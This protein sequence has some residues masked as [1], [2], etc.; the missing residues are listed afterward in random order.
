MTRGRG[1]LSML[2]LLLAAVLTACTGLPT[3]GTVNY[4]LGA[5]DAPD[6]DEVS[7]LL[8]DRPQP[9]ATPE[10]IVE[11]FIRAGSGPGLAANWDRAREFLTRE[12]ADGWDPRAGVTVDL[13]EDR[14]YSEPQTGAVTLSLRA[15]A[16]VDDQGSYAPAEVGART[17]AFE[18]LQRDDGEWRISAA[19]DGVVLGRDE[20]PRVFNRYSL[21]YF[22]PTGEYLVPDARW[23]P[24][25][26]A[27]A[28]I[29]D[30]LVN[31]APS[32]WLAES[33]DSAFPDAVGLVPA[34]PVTAGGVAEVDLSEAALSVDPLTMD[35][36]YT[37]LLES[38]KTTGVSSLQL[39]VGLTPIEAEAVPVRS[40]RVGG[41]P[42]VRIEEGFGFLTGDELDEIA[43][44]S[45]MIEQYPVVAVQVAPDRDVAA[46]RLTS[47]AVMR[48]GADQSFQ[49]LDSRAGLVDPTIDPFGFIWTV[50]RGAPAA[51]QAH[52]PD[53]TIIEVID[54]WSGATGIEA[55]AVSR[56]GTRM[57]A[58]VTTGGT[59]AL[60]VAGVVRGPDNALRLGDPVQLGV[61]EGAGRGLAW[62][63]DGSLGVLSSGGEGAVVLEQVVGGLPSTTTVAVPMAS[64]AGGTSLSSVR[65]RAE[66]GTL[67]VNRGTSWQPTATG[68]LVLATQ[69]GAPQ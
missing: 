31:G 50:P 61:V 6:S 44:L 12:F 36:M 15:V 59:T 52:A 60:W 67:Y 41:A 54:A 48:L 40:T 58:I 1:I 53:G 24:P 23:F 14:V 27:P 65:L 21:M 63:D 68:V 39:A 66:D 10:E 32:S 62:L 8:P 42:L 16:T 11:G 26:N 43:G 29:A 9:G 17:L 51:V 46:V 35:R 13:F 5:E 64:I 20:F 55:M 2:V 19:P 4:G 37:Q 57:A 28:R 49:T 34:V 45:D 25:T 18:L 56:D 30:E 47:G 38:L 7:F 3:S 69:Q 33:V 22:D